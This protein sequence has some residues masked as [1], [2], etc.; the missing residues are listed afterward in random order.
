M[1]RLTSAELFIREDNGPRQAHDDGSVSP[2]SYRLTIE[3]D[4]AGTDHRLVA[5]VAD[6]VSGLVVR[7][8]PTRINRFERLFAT[9][10]AAMAAADRWLLVTKWTAP[11]GWE[12]TADGRAMK[13][14]VVYTVREQR[15]EQ[16]TTG[17]VA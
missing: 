2:A 12:P 11:T 17:T 16:A 7:R 13:R 15:A 3:A 10:M 1:A 14:A 5:D 8:P 4:L 6:T 9:P